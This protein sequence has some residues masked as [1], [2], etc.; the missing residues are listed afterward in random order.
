MSM[1]S[2]SDAVAT[3]TFSSPRLS[4][5]S[6]SSRSSRREAAVVRGDRL[7]AEPLAEVARRALGHAPRVDEHQRRA[8]RAHQLGDARRRPAP[9][10]R[11]TSPP[12]AASAARSSARSRCL[13]VADV[14][15]L[16]VGAP[17][18]DGAG[19]DQEARDLVDRLLRRRQADAHQRRRRAQRLQPLQRQRQVAAALARR[20]R[21]DLVD[22][23]ACAPSRSIVAPG[24]RAEQ[25]VQRL[26]RR[27]QDVRRLAQRSAGARAAA[28][29]RCA[30]RCG[31]STSGR[32]SARQLARGC[33]P[34][35][36]RG[37]GGCRSTAPSAARRRPPRVSSGRP[38]G[39]R[40][41]AHQRVDARP[42]TRPAS[43][44]SRSARRPACGG[45]RGS[46]ARRRPAPRSAPGTRAANQRG[47]G[48]MEG[49]EGHG[50]NRHGSGRSRR[51]SLPI[52]SG[53]CREC[54]AQKTTSQPCH[55]RDARHDYY[56][57]LRRMDDDMKRDPEPVPATSYRLA[58]NRSALHGR[59]FLTGIQALVRLPAD[60][61]AA[62]R[63]AWPEYGRLHLAATAARRWAA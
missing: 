2:S 49:F 18:V 29:R 8:V 31:S 30:P 41:C 63:G 16:A 21:V 4:R 10:A 12:P 6:A 61:A 11:S 23:H 22:D 38:P 34:A 20:D 19:A 55:G 14:D 53:L 35:A 7:L 50:Q 42:G 36:P 43:C 48:G 47:D 51:L 26:G 25:H 57:F 15:D 45:R 1:P 32:P 58:D 62:R 24:L 5:C 39:S 60:A 9:T 40:P 3:S 13:R 46:P 37:S 54:Q 28:C 33:R 56:L 27:H 44:P 59:V 52:D 17:S